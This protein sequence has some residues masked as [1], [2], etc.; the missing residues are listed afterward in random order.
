MPPL[1]VVL[2]VLASAGFGSA[3]LAPPGL[4]RA[5]PA[6][7][8]TYCQPTDPGLDELSGMTELNGELWAMGDSG[9][10][11]RI[12]RLAAIAP[13]GRCPV[14][15]WAANPVDPFDVEDLATYGGALWLSD[16]GD[17]RRVRST[18]ALVRWEPDTGAGELH[19]LTF[20]D[21]PHDTEALLIGRTGVP[22]LITK[23]LLGPAQVYVPVDDIPVD[24]LASP[25]PTP[26][27][28]VGTARLD[29]VSA[30]GAPR[31]G[32]MVTGAAV[33][34][35]GRAAAVRTY[36]EV[37]L[38][39]VSD[40]DVAAAVTGHVP[41]AIALPAQPQGESAAF[42]PN[43]DLIF[44]SETGGTGR[45]LP[46]L[47]VLPGAAQLVAPDPVPAPPATGAAASGA[48]TPGRDRS[49]LLVGLAA[50]GV[51]AVGLLLHRRRRR[52]RERSSTIAR[53]P[54]ES[55]LS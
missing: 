23:D 31:T 45:P 54:G 22:V 30:T 32:S 1:A 21:G 48:S 29:A 33:S 18:V 13:D 2:W 8:T 53:G 6:A 15:E 34:V 50:I 39:P 42:A 35:D 27:R 7:V 51:V 55:T 40:G 14:A 9:T 12:A 17:N 36:G 38:F 3:L 47:L 28:Y 10:D 25:G 20:P 4:A 11:E 5:E 26:L 46:P 49:G 19:R 44:G 52:S 16:T 41:V 24:R 43:G 37:Y